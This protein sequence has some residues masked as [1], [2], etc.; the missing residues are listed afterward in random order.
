[1]RHRPGKTQSPWA[2]VEALSADGSRDGLALALSARE[3]PEKIIRAACALGAGTLE[4]ARTAL[5]GDMHELLRGG[6]LAKGVL[7]L[8]QVLRLLEDTGSDGRSAAIPPTLGHASMGHTPRTSRHG[9]DA[10]RLT[11]QGPGGVDK[12]QAA[13]CCALACRC[14][15]RSASSPTCMASYPGY[16]RSAGPEGSNAS[17]EA[18][19]VQA[20]TSGLEAPVATAAARGKRGVTGT[21]H[22]LLANPSRCSRLVKRLNTA[23]K[24]VTVAMM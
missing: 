6:T 24:R 12:P 20:A 15:I 16:A 21:R 2:L 8:E 18:S 17:R 5:A 11:V 13:S 19:W 1:M 22:S 3:D 23:T 4:G 7:R 9:Y 10:D 14:S